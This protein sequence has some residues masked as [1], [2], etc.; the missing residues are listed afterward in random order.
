MLVISM[1]NQPLETV[2]SVDQIKG[3]VQRYGH[4]AGVRHLRNKG[5]PLEHVL[6][7]LY[8]RLQPRGASA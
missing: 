2:M 8:G 4:Y 7:A 1:A 6:F 3:V 5:I